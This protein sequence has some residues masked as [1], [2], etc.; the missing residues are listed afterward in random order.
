LR[1]LLGCYETALNWTFRARAAQVP[2]RYATFQSTIAHFTEEMIPSFRDW[3]DQLYRDAAIMAAALN[4]GQTPVSTLHQLHW[5]IP[6]DVTKALLDTLRPQG[7]E[8]DLEGR[9]N[10]VGGMILLLV[11]LAF[12]ALLFKACAALGPPGRGAWD[13]AQVRCEALHDPTASPQTARP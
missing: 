2:T 12:I 6:A 5:E 1:S 13:E 7:R 9:T 3:V 10:V 11:V 4:A 8:T